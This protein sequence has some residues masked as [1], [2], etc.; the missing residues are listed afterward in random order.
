[1]AIK[2]LL[3]YWILPKKRHVIHQCG[4]IIFTCSPN[5]NFSTGIHGSIKN[6]L[7][8]MET[9]QCAKGSLD[10]WNVLHIMKKLLSE[11]FFGEPKMVLL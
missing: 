4:F 6:F 1:M 8:S 5:T 7:T 11:K 2:T 9:F 3:D 10:Y